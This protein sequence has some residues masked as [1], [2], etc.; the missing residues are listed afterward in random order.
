MPSCCCRAAAAAVPQ[1]CSAAAAT[2]AARA[3][4]R[5]CKPRRQLPCTSHALQHH[6]RSEPRFQAAQET[7]RMPPCCTAVQVSTQ[8]TAHLKGSS[9]SMLA[10]SKSTTGHTSGEV[11]ANKAAAHSCR[12]L[13][14]PSGSSTSLAA[15]ATSCL[16]HTHHQP[17]YQQVVVAVAGRSS[18]KHI[19]SHRPLSAHRTD[20]Q[21]CGDAPAGGVAAADDRLSSLLQLPALGQRVLEQH[22]QM[23]LRHEV[24]HLRDPHSLA[25]R[26]P[27]WKN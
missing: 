12:L 5:L 4:P 20:L 22:T 25:A 8:C 10:Q 2:C 27:G 16:W 17:A 15:A 21:C 19:S 3:S 7:A 24:P 13:S 6:S 11:V 14:A 9:Y 1:R 26:L 18:S 23:A